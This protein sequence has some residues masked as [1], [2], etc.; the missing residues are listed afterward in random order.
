MFSTQ[1]TYTY[2]TNSLV[3]FKNL[4]RVGSGLK[5]FKKVAW[6]RVRFQTRRVPWGRVWKANVSGRAGFKNSHFSSSLP[7]AGRQPKV[8]PRTE[9]LPAPLKSIQNEKGMIV[10]RLAKLDI[11]P[12]KDRTDRSHFGRRS[13]LNY[14]TKTFA[15]VGINSPTFNLQMA[16]DNPTSEF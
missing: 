15:C 16:A 2:F 14:I 8:F 12:N 9:I 7:L 1:F 5:F 4:F 13:S 3:S 6:G 11:Y 10:S